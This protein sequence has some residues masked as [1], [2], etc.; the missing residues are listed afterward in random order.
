MSNAKLTAVGV[1]E[2]PPSWGVRTGGVLHEPWDWAAGVPEVRALEPIRSVSSGALSRHVPVRARCTTTGS[3]LL[4]ESG[5]EHELVTWL[6]RQ[7]AVSWL[8][9]QPV[10]L[11]WSD[12]LRH[13]PDLLSLDVSG[14]VTVWDVR[15]L[16][17]RDE[18]F[19]VQSARTEAECGRI[20]WSHRTFGGLPHVASLNL[21]WIA[22][23][24]RPPEWLPMS[25]PIL[26]ELVASGPR[27]VGEL[28]EADDGR[29][30]LV[31][32]MWHLVWTGDLVMDLTVPWNTDTPVYWR[33]E[34]AS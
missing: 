15:P 27:T 31:A 14:T 24:R 9:A 4:L 8:A 1:L 13:Y 22:G 30:Y 18:K 19:D 26:H 25:A 17:R 10:R 12:G 3:A 29:G 28:V 23:A 32:A 11:T 33:Q 7:P 20:G 16:E 34:E 6:D 2:G 21:R 5:L